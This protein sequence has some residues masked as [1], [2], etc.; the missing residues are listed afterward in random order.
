[1]KKMQIAVSQMETNI[2]K[3]VCKLSTKTL[4]SMQ[5]SVQVAQTSFSPLSLKQHPVN[6]IHVNNSG[7]KNCLVFVNKQCLI[8]SCSESFFFPKRAKNCLSL[9]KCGNSGIHDFL[10]YRH[11]FH[12]KHKMAKGMSRKFFGS[13]KIMHARCWM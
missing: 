1:M 3:N 10:S 8:L 4:F 7:M 12:L 11:L 6:N 2:Q 5:K 13:T 9:M